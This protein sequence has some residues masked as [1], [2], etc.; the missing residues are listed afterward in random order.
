MAPPDKQS[1][2]YTELWN[3]F[4]RITSG[5]SAA[6]KA[7][8]SGTAARVYRLTTLQIEDVEFHRPLLRFAWL[9]SAWLRLPRY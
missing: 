1:G 2:G 6:E 9:A 3:P 8:Y 4:K 5:V 7:L